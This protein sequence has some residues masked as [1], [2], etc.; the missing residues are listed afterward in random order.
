MNAEVR[1]RELGLKLPEVPKPVA[2]Y[3]PISS[4]WMSQGCCTYCVCVSQSTYSDEAV[5]DSMS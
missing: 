1:L 3:V 4:S 5:R 2:E